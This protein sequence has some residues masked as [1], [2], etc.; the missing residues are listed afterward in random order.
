MSSLKKKG[1]K[2]WRSSAELEDS[3]EFRERMEREFPEPLEAFPPNSPERRRFLQVMGAS[4]S[5]AG[6][7]GCRWHEDKLLPLTRRPED[8]T[9]GTT[10]RFAT[11]MELGGVAVGLHATSYEGRPIKIDGNPLHPESLGACGV[12]QQASVLELYDP[13]RSQYALFRQE[14]KAQ[15]TT[16]DKFSE[17]AKQHFSRLRS[18]RGVG[19]RILSERS[20]SPTLEM[21]R[22]RL[23]AAAPEAKWVSF[24]PVSSDGPRQGSVLAFGKPHRTHYDF[25]AA[26]VIVALDADLLSPTFPANL[27]HAKEISKRRVAEGEMNR[28]YAIESSYSLLGGMADHR[29]PLRSELIKAVAAALDSDVSAKASPLPEL[30]AAQSKPNAQFLGDPGVSKFLAAV[31]K[32]LLGAVGRSVVVAGPQQPASVHALAHRLNAILGNVGRTVFYSEDPLASE[33]S[34]AE[35]LSALTAELEANQVDTL[36][37]LG[38]NPAY[39]A[40]ADVNFAA[41][42]GKA[43][44]SI[45]L[46]LYQDETTEL[47]TWHLPAAHYLESWGDARAW[48]GTVSLVQPLIAPL[49]GGLSAIELVAMVLGDGAKALELVRR[50]H[51]DRLGSEKSF[52]KAIHDG[53]ISG[54]AFAR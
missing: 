15:P 4:L 47:A 25:N 3:P 54:S 53:V 17:F 12:Y 7:T 50:A 42:L 34:D 1:L 29:L 21:L 24:E 30:G 6:L 52:R 11:S 14:G 38:G 28:I 9:P 19:L 39:S 20:S 10:R 35:S 31:V 8:Y 41:A 33:S 36:L 48:D 2:I 27:R 5:L 49:Y 23:L 37:I 26:D 51:Q 43:K 46:S 22:K 32:D 40:P 18:M 45:H 13:D 44:T 16:V